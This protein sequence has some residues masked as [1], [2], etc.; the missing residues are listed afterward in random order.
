MI[1][2]N[3]RYTI[4]VFT[5]KFHRHTQQNHADFSPVEALTLDGFTASESRER[6]NLTELPQLWSI[7]T[8]EQIIQLSK[9]NRKDHRRD[10]GLSIT[11]TNGNG[12]SGNWPYIKSQIG[13]H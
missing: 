5:E 1:Q 12:F 3:K 13:Q 2:M 9:Q 6:E 10:Q 4:S 8:E 7:H 11:W